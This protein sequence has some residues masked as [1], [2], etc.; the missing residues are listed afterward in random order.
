MNVEA[1]KSSELCAECVEVSVFLTRLA[2]ILVQT[3]GLREPHLDSRGRITLAAI[4]ISEHEQTLIDV[5]L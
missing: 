4:P 3:R 2:C 1:R 5:E